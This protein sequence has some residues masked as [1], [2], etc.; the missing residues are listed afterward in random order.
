MDRMEPAYNRASVY[1]TLNISWR[2]FSVIT[3][4]KL[5]QY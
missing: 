2:Y 5:N 1:D 3:L 4:L